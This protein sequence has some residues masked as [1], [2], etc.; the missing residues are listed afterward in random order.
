MTLRRVFGGLIGCWGL[1]GWISLCFFG[2][3]GMVFE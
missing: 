2:G 3:V 1:V